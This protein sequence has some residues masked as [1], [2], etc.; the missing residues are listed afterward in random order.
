MN[1][2]FWMMPK[3][4]GW[5]NAKSQQSHAGTATAPGMDR[6]AGTAYKPPAQGITA[7]VM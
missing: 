4:A 2:T 1:A 3:S 7:P 5:N 6:T